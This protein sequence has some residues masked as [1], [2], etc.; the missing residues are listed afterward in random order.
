MIKCC[1]C[2]KTHSLAIVVVV[3]WVLSDAHPAACADANKMV[4]DHHFHD[5]NCCC[6]CWCRWC[7]SHDSHNWIVL[8][9][10]KRRLHPIGSVGENIGGVVFFIQLEHLQWNFCNGN[11]I[12]RRRPFADAYSTVWLI[13]S[14]SCCVLHFGLDCIELNVKSAA[15]KWRL[16]CGFREHTKSFEWKIHTHSQS[17]ANYHFGQYHL[18]RFQ[19]Q[20]VQSTFKNVTVVCVN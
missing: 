9:Y 14:I 7:N 11:L 6:C 12:R 20:L 5:F 13:I 18:R 2:C 10:H 3:V 8:I 1:C 15:R 4:A 17:N 16:N 19:L